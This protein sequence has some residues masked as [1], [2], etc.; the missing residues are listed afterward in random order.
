MTFLHIWS[1]RVKSIYASLTK[2]LSRNWL[3]ALNL[4]IPV[5]LSK[6]AVKVLKKVTYKPCDLA[7]EEYWGQG[8]IS[9][10]VLMTLTL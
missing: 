3:R 10:A 7:L 5:Y 9:K 8:N 1:C 4:F 2:L 6:P